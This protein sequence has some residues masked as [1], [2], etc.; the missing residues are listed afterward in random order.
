MLQIRLFG[1]GLNGQWCTG[2][3]KRHTPK[4]WKSLEFS[5]FGTLIP[6]LCCRGVAM[7]FDSNKDL[8]VNNRLS[9]LCL[10]G[11]LIFPVRN[12]SDR[13]SLYF[14][15]QWSPKVSTREAK[16]WGL[17]AEAPNSGLRYWQEGG[18]CVLYH[19]QN[20]QKFFWKTRKRERCSEQILACTKEA[21][22]RVQA[23]TE[24]RTMGTLGHL[25]GGFLLSHLITLLS[26]SAPLTSPSFCV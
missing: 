20:D 2:S 12:G 25:I 18:S 26:R 5:L 19:L 21:R 4:P 15:G 23:S 8:C 10:L 14:H 7:H 6:E 22:R 3:M 1:L 13:C 24:G 17:K 11:H 9:T 16:P